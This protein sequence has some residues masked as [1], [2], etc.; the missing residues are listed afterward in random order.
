MNIIILPQKIVNVQYTETGAL[1]NTSFGNYGVRIQSW[2][3]VSMFA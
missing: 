3:L 1:R 2:D